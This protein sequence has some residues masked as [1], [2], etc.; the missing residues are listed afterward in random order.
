MAVGHVGVRHRAERSEERG[1]LRNPP[2]G[3][4]YSVRRGEVVERRG[5]EDGRAQRG[6]IGTAAVG[7][8]DRLRVGLEREHVPG[9]V[10]LLVLPGL[11]VLPDDVV[12][13][14]VDV[15]AAHDPGLRPPVHDLAIEVERRSLLADERPLGLEAVERRPGLGIDPGVVRIDVSGQIDV[16]PADVE[17]AVRVSLRQRGRFGPIHHVVGHRRHALG[18]LGRGT[19]GAERRQTHAG[20]PIARRT[21]TSRGHPSGGRHLNAREGGRAGGRE[22]VRAGGREGVRA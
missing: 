7:E 14:V 18:E 2:D 10:V 17:E 3:V 21:A 12:L 20:T 16:G 9:A 6:D 8:K 11:L 4:A 22:G 15:D 1:R 13:V 5:L 19:N